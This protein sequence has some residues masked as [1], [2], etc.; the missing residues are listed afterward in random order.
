MG[1]WYASSS[2]QAILALEYGFLALPVILIGFSLGVTAVSKGGGPHLNDKHK[3]WGVALF[4]LYL[5]QISLGGFV[6]FYKFPFAQI[7][8]R[9]FQNYFHAAF[10]IFIIAAAF[11]QVC[12]P[13]SV[14]I[15]HSFHGIVRRIIRYAQALGLNGQCTLVEA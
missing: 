14:A 1:S 12:L 9:S 5:A 15:S 6:H 4:V 7:H 11:Y 13:A 8:R 2:S 3:K 10:G